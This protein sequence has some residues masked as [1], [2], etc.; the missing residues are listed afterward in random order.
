MKALKDSWKKVRGWADKNSASIFTGWIVALIMAAIMIT[1]DMK[2]A[3]KEIDHLANEI[4]LTKE[5]NELAKTTVMQFEMINELLKTSTNQRQ[6]L[7]SA[8]EAL[9]EQS[10]L[11]QR[12]V[13]YLKRIGHWP[14]KI[15]PPKP[16]DPDK[17]I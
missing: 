12:L 13:D 6:G 17:W 2:H 7:E 16:A 4:E 10:M 9:N 1:K 8:T 15:N 5:N 11:I 3:S 14:P